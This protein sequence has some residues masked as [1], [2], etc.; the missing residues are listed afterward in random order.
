MLSNKIRLL[1][2][3]L[4]LIL[5][6]LLGSFVIGSLLVVDGGTLQLENLARLRWQGT[7]VFIIFL[8]L[9]WVALHYLLSNILKPLEQLPAY[10]RKIAEEKNWPTEEESFPGSDAITAEAN[11]LARTMRQCRLEKAQE[12][13]KLSL[14]MDNMDNGVAMFE[15]EGALLEGNKRF[16]A[17]FEL[18]QGT[19]L[20]EETIFHNAAFSLFLRDLLVKNKAGNFLLRQAEKGEQKIFQ[21]FGV[22]LLVA[23]RHEPS[24]VLLVFHDITL[25]QKVYER[26]TAFVSNASHELATPLTTIK[27]F[28]ET[29]AGE[30]NMDTETRNKFLQIIVA[31]SNRMQLLL[32][33]LLQLAKLD[34]AE[35]RKN[36]VIENINTIGL[37]EEL[38]T[39][40]AQQVITRN[41]H[42]TVQYEDKPLIKTNMEWLKQILINLLEN[43]LKYTPMGGEIK[44]TLGRGKDMA[45]FTVFNSGEGLGEED[46]EKIF[47][48]FYR[49]DASHNHKIQ[50]SGLGLSIV[51]FAVEM[52]GGTIRTESVPGQGVSFIFT[53]PLA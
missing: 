7:I 28:A 8:L 38:Q 24:R 43:A 52:L 12:Q 37:L 53:V 22:P 32:K 17:M 18:E 13:R 29:V 34:S 42:M 14:I 15:E 39:E 40:F 49:A 46:K 23:F 51:K 48:R 20:K 36:V 25:L 44:V 10:L 3:G 45:V 4:F 50:G 33:D 2:E 1:S 6:L 5:A 16:F 19:H 47:A 9:F 41:L 31:E 21:V 11:D 30:K 35:Y 26:Q 27:G